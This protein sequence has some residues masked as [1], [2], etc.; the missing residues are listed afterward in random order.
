MSRLQ[1]FCL[2]GVR[3]Q[4]DRLRLCS[5]N[6]TIEIQP[7]VM[8]VIVALAASD[9]AVV[10]RAQLVERVWGQTSVGYD[11]LARAIYE[12]RKAFAQVAPGVVFIETVPQR[13]YRLC[14]VPESAADP[15]PSH[16][17]RFRADGKAPSSASLRLVGA[18]IVAL[19]LAMHSF[20]MHGSPA[21]LLGVAGI[22]A[23]GLVRR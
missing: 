7:K 10:P 22:L 19:G 16:V 3:V 9:D 13:G 23:A 2:R 6:T 14:A 4:P 15:A 11:A 18:A 21:H 17:G 8:D 1:D 5:A 12:A 20:R